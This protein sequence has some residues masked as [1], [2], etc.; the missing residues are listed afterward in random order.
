MPAYSLADMLHPCPILGRDSTTT[1]TRFSRGQWTLVRCV[2]TGFVFLPDPPA[3]DALAGEHAWEST[4]AAERA[5]RRR[6]DPVFTGLGAWI[7]R[8]R[9]RLFRSRNPFAA[10]VGARLARSNRASPACIVDVGC[11]HAA[12]TR[13]I[14]ERLGARGFA[15]RMTGI[16]V[17]PALAAAA[18]ET[19]GPIGGAVVE[20]SALEG[21]R[22]LESESVT[23]ILMSSFLEHE[24]QPL[25]LLHEARRCMRPGGFVVVKVPNFA[26]WNR[27]LRGARWCGFRYPDHVNYFTPR[28]LGILAERASLRFEQGP[29]D[30][31]PLSD[32]MYAVLS[33]REVD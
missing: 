33:R 30:R 9:R 27:L 24:A 31:F 6:E 25:E 28:T 17:S 16:E 7:N 12:F 1:P 3:Y 26:C 14:A 15:V 32:N 4:F 20:A 10:I 22:S 11:S 18:R 29:L 21:L 13:A 2:E 23:A 8:S 5:R 19:L